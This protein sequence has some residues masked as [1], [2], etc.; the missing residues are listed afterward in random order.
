[1]QSVFGLGHQTF[2]KRSVEGMQVL[3]R[4]GHSETGTQVEME[5]GVPDGGEIH[6]NHAAVGLLKGQGGIDCG[7]SG[8]R[9]SFCA[10]ECETASFAHAPSSSG[11]VGTET[12]ESFK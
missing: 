10:E 6:Q 4:V 12:R 8:A 1:M 3:A 7:R 9:A 2:E 11:A 5:L